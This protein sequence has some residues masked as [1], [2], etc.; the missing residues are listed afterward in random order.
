MNRPFFLDTIKQGNEASIDER[1]RKCC[2]ELEIE[3][4]SCG[5]FHTKTYSKSFRDRGDGETRNVDL[6]ERCLTT[7][8]W[9]R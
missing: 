8:A 2:D 5:E 6:C 4:W 9:L 3:C 1:Y 7:G